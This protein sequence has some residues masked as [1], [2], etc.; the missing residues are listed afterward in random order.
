MVNK[1]NT[2]IAAAYQDW[3]DH[4]VVASYQDWLDH[5]VVV[6]NQD[7]LDHIVVASYQD[8]LDHTVVVASYQDWLDHTVVVAHLVVDCTIDAGL[9]FVFVF[10]SGSWW[11]VFQNLFKKKEKNT[12]IPILS[13]LFLHEYCYKLELRF[14]SYPIFTSPPHICQTVLVWFSSSH[15]N[16]CN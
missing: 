7:W 5:I 8:W 11:I 6:S 3:L 16:S 9:W 13:I 12:M 2:Y 1:R 15:D 4:T 14:E 10:P